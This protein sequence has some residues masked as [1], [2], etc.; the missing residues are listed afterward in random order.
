MRQEEHYREHQHGFTLLRAMANPRVWLL[1]LVYFTVSMGANSYGAFL[2]KI[3]EESFE[4]VSKSE[5]GLLGAIPSTVTIV[6]MVL[7]GMHSDRTGER[8]WH[9]ALSAFVAAV[10]WIMVTQ[11]PAPYVL[12]GLILA[13]AGMLS[14]LA[15]FWSLPTAFLSGAAAAGGIA[16][17][18]SVGNLGGF[19]APNVI[20][21]LKAE[22]HSYSG[23]LIF[24]AV[25]LVVGGLLALAV[26]HDATLDRVHQGP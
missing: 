24:L 6:A 8:R 25:A 26:R 23:G 2:P 19:V 12:L 21:R 20:S 14:M 5:I 1:C 18:N 11:L 15:P 22:T 16:M 7:I 3:L 4:H 9:V 10:G 17:I 13:H